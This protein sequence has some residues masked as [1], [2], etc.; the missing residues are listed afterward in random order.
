MATSDLGKA[1]AVA[2]SSLAI[3]T[4]VAWYSSSLKAAV[5]ASVQPSAH[6]RTIMNA[7]VVTG[8][9][10]FVGGTL[11]AWLAGKKEESRKD[12]KDENWKKTQLERWTAEDKR[13]NQD[14]AEA[15]VQEDRKKTERDK[16][17][18]LQSIKEDQRELTAIQTM[19]WQQQEGLYISFLGANRRCGNCGVP[20]PRSNFRKNDLVSRV[21]WLTCACF[22]C[23]TTLWPNGKHERVWLDDYKLQVNWK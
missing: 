13:K 22:G 14:A 20:Y 10:L 1:T 23:A 5:T 9:S 17:E 7:L 4:G 19:P 3:A 16:A 2:G 15:K 8:I 6:G 12:T 21:N 11:W 18:E